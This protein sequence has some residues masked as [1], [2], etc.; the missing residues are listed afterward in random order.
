MMDF[1]YFDIETIPAQADETRDWLVASVKAPGNLKDPAKIEAA[2]A[3][4]RAEAVSKSS[5][6]GLA[7]HVC[8]IAWEGPDGEGIAHASDVSQER[9]VLEAFFRA[10]PYQARLTLVGHNVLGFDIPFLTRRALVLGVKLPQMACWPRNPRPWDKSVQDTMQMFGGQDMV[11]LDRACRA[12]GIP[13]KD[14][15]DGSQVAEAWANG[16]HERIME[17][18][19]DD[20]RRTRAVHERFLAVGW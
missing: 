1:L 4:K 5:F 19:A 9:G 8:T 18:A 14:G 15:F 6:D 16:E 2:L 20:V 3:E 12:L 11:S 13:G 17:Y 10:V 7:G